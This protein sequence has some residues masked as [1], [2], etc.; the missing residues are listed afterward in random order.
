MK[1]TM[2]KPINVATSWRVTLTHDRR[3][4]KRCRWSSCMTR[5]SRA[6]LKCGKKLG[7]PNR[8]APRVFLAHGAPRAADGNAIS[9]VGSSRLQ[10]VPHR[11]AAATGRGWG[12]LTSPRPTLAHWM[13]RHGGS[14]PSKTD[15]LHPRYVSAPWDP[16]AVSGGLTAH[17]RMHCAAVSQRLPRQN[18]SAEQR[19]PAGL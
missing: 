15:R 13:P 10:R 1:S 11:A 18:N 3:W 17:V 7:R 12:C 5:G 8:R 9:D 2:R 14:R 19:S 16:W 4:N 6:A